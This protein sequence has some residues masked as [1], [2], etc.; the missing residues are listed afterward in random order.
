[1]A[2]CKTTTKVSDALVF[3]QGFICIGA[4]L[5]VGINVSGMGLATDQQCY[6]AIRVCV[7]MYTSAKIALYVGSLVTAKWSY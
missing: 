1:M 5:S 2:G 3:I 4:L 7:A 6:S